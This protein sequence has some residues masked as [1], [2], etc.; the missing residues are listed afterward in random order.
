[1]KSATS[2]LVF[3]VAA[4]LALGLVILYSSSVAERGTH[5]LA[6]QLL[7]CV[8]GL[9]GCAIAAGMDYRLLKKLAVPLL[10]FTVLLLVLVFVPQLGQLEMGHKVKGASRWLRVPHMEVGIQPSEFAKLVLIIVLAWYGDRYQR[11]MGT[12]KK[13]MLYPGLLLGV[14]MG[15]IFI[16]PDRGTTILMAAVLGAMFLVAGVRWK[17][18]LPAVL[19]GAVFLTFS[20]LRDPMRLRRILAWL[21]PDQHKLD[22]GLQANYAMLALG[23][24]GWTG[25]GLGN[26]RQKLGFLPEHNTD[27]IFSIIGEELGLIATLLVVVGFL[28]NVISGIYIASRSNDMFGLLLGVGISFLIGLQAFINIGVVTGVLPNKGL[29]LPFI[30]YGGSNLVMML[31]SVGLLL[32]VAR[33]ARVP[34]KDSDESLEPEGVPIPQPA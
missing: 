9:T 22:A 30:S 33:R 1:M 26:S 10:L 31:T 15:L 4:L 16:E 8:L 7:W 3:C 28:L 23:S 12:W 25:L 20:L 2:T 19:S 21:N 11:Q 5:F 17:F 6:S 18:I 32:G 14:V 27:F 13:G 29:A 34:S 24:G